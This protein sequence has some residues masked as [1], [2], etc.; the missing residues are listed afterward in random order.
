MQINGD[1]GH[2]ITTKQILQ[3]TV[4]VATG[5]QK[6]GVKRGD[7]IGVCSENRDEYIPTVLAVICSGATVTTLNVLYTKG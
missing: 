3:D 6:M 1:T 2:K 4:N 5:L 7:V